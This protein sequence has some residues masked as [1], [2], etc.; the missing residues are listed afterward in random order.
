MRSEDHWKEHARG[1]TW[2]G[3]YGVKDNTM[4]FKLV[5]N[6]MV[7][8]LEQKLQWKAE[9]SNLHEQQQIVIVRYR[10]TPEKICNKGPRIHN[11]GWK[12]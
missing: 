12:K 6:Q 1:S 10:D 9:L 7:W 4:G 3:V 11:E 2:E 5:L 8:L